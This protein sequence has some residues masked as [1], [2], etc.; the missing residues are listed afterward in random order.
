MVLDTPEYNLII[1]KPLIK[2]LLIQKLWYAWANIT[3]PTEIAIPERSLLDT[4]REPTEVIAIIGLEEA[5]LTAEAIDDPPSL[6]DTSQE[7]V[8]SPSN[9]RTEEPPWPHASMHRYSISQNRG[10]DRS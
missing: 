2:Y 9:T 8:A 3:R 1:G 5:T 10:Q 7:L 6:L 4:S